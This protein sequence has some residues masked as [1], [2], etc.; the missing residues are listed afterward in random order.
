MS[1]KNISYL[2]ALCGVSVDY[3]EYIDSL[4]SSEIHVAHKEMFDNDSKTRIDSLK[5][6]FYSVINEKKKRIVSKISTHCQEHSR[7]KDIINK[8][9]NKYG[10]LKSFFENQFLSDSTIHSELTLQYRNKEKI[11]DEDIELL[12]EALYENGDLKIEED[13]D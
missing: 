10:S 1:N 13:K 2:Q 5:N 9:K 7:D 12:I 6:I 4:N 3:L 8:V 11:T